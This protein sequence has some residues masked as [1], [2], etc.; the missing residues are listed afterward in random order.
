[1]RVKYEE[2]IEKKRGLKKK[3]EQTNERVI[4]DTRD[5]MENGNVTRDLFIKKRERKKEETR[6]NFERRRNIRIK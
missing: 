5:G 2:E 6:S 4:K 1:M 3:S